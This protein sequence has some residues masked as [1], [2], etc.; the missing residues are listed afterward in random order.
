MTTE[1]FVSPRA[2]SGG[3]LHGMRQALHSMKIHALTVML[4]LTVTVGV[5]ADDEILVSDGQTVVFAGDDL[6]ARG[7]SEFG[8]LVRAVADGLARA[9]VKITPLTVAADGA[10]SSALAAQLEAAL[11]KHPAWVALLC[12]LNDTGPRGVSAAE[13]QRNLAAAV[14]RSLSA[15]ARVLLL[16]VPVA[17]RAAADGDA[18]AANNGFLRELAREKNLSLAD[19]AADFAAFLQNNPPQ[20]GTLALTVDGAHWNAEG[21]VIAARCVL[22]ALGVPAAAL[23]KL[24]DEWRRS[25]PVAVRATVPDF[26]PLPSEFGIPWWQY[27]ALDKIAVGYGSDTRMLN[28]TLFMRALGKVL[29]RHPQDEVL[30]LALMVSETRK[31]L[32]ADLDALTVKDRLAMSPSPSAA[33][34]SS[35][36]GPLLVK[37]GERV[38]FMGDSITAN[39][40]SVLGGYV[41]LI[42]DGLRRAGADIVPVT[43][44]VGG[45]KSSDMVERLRANVLAKQPDWL[46]LS[47]GVNDVW[48]WSLSNRRGVTLEDYRANVSGIV[49]QAR[50]AGTRVMLLTPT[51]V[52]EDLDNDSNRKLAGYV[53][54]MREIARDNNLP[55]ADMNAAVQAALRQ[56][57]A[58]PARTF[59]L[60]IDGVHMNP[61]GNVVMAREG[62]RAFGV[63]PAALARIEREWQALPV[64]YFV[65]WAL[66]PLPNERS[67]P[68]GAWRALHRRA[69][70]LGADD[71]ALTVTL[72]LRAWREILERHRDDNI[73]DMDRLRAE[74]QV[75]LCEDITAQEL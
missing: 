17:E 66:W 72:Y 28:V 65:G 25:L 35:S 5:A 68:L 57:P 56:Y 69:Q 60:T 51:P 24:D 40:Y 75:L 8:G 43:D 31:Q 74:A 73:L 39:G 23:A 62:L 54:A 46:T 29:D 18:T 4:A 70:A 20:P 16:T 15:G 2:L 34:P 3:K 41:N 38:A 64:A 22:R 53:A 71:N 27:R 45:S 42:V 26:W 58:R 47:C 11:A 1:C 52:G 44:G 21:N 33:G 55:L 13:Y 37:S 30:D 59:N 49:A 14:D 32:L 67:V 50:A 61:G 63:P 36:A 12:G 48:H 7:A 19:V 6:A 10:K 9:G